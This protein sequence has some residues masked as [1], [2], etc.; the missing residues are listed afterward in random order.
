MA[1][2]LRNLWEWADEHHQGELDSGKRQVRPPVL[3]KTFASKGILV[4][5]D[6]SKAQIIRTTIPVQKRHR[7]FRSLKSSQ[8]LSQ[9]VFGAIHAFG[10][11]D[12]LQGLTAD[13]GRPAFFGNSSGQ[14]L[15][16][17]H[18]IHWLQEPR[19]TS[20]DV[21]FQGQEIRVA[22]ECKFTEREFGTCS[23]PRLRPGDS[24]Y[25]EQYCDGN[26]R[27]QQGRQERCAL[28]EIGILYWQYLPHL[29]NWKVDYDHL[30]CPFRDVYQLARNALAA[31]FTPEGEFNP[32]TGH[33]LVVYDARNPE[34]QQNG[35]AETQWSSATEDSQIRGLVRRLS[36]QR[37]I[38]VFAHAPELEYLVSAVA[39]KYGL[40]PD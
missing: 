5:S 17:E 20:V 35:K 3:Q 18:E 2:V 14:S 12:L 10:R 33:V 4:P 21:L 36:W 1:S 9:S 34:Y 23:R 40:K 16:F 25:P 28:E 19:R 32:A 39:R 37:L 26:Y 11:L 7:W 6:F 8:A 30:P 15:K 27:V 31:A 22:V 13:C 24:G 38:A 29:F